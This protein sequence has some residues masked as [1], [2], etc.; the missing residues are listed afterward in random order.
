MVDPYAVND[1]VFLF[2][3]AGD[4]ADPFTTVTQVTD[5]LDFV[6]TVEGWREEIPNCVCGPGRLIGRETAKER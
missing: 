6:W 3:Y 1:A 5:A 4:A 2:G